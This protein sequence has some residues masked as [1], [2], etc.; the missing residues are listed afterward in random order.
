VVGP[1]RDLR[2]YGAE[3]APASSTPMDRL[4]AYLGYRS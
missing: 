2:H 4:V 1:E 3:L